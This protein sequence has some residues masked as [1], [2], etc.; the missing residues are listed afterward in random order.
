MCAPAPARV[1]GPPNVVYIVVADL[2]YGDLACYGHPTIRTPSLDR[3]AREGMRFTDFYSA[4][5]VC[6][7]SRAAML[8]GRYAARTGMAS[9][10]RRVLF[11]NSS[12][13]LPRSEVTVAELLKGKGY[14]TAC[15]GKWHL[16]HL[17][18]F[19]PDRHGF[20]F[21]MVVPYSNDM[22]FVP[23][24][25][26]G[27]AADLEPKNEWFRVPV[28]RDGKQVERPAVQATLT[29]R[30]TDDV[31]EVV[32]RNRERSFFVY[33]AHTMPH[34]PL[35]ASDEFRGKS[36]R[37]LYGDVVEELDANVGR[38]LEFLAKEGM[39]KNTLVVFTSDNGPWLTRGLVGGSAG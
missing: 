30:S 18:T 34:V 13:G 2:G 23:R 14:A 20:D 15:I 27:P 31:M 33:L 29:R 21:Y 4:S 35:F 28:L 7:P 26:R 25:P 1:F 3:M 8:T 24:S 6:T 39:D 12:G 17:P 11:P 37:G 19:L 9:D 36:A 5:S 38:V 10:K 22:D 32:G 16:G